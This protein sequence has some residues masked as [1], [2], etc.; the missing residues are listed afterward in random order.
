[1]NNN[2]R[3]AGGGKG[4]PPELKNR[5][6]LPLEGQKFGNK[7]EEFIAYPSKFLTPVCR[8]FIF[9]EKFF[10]PKTEKKLRI[11][12]EKTEKTEK[13]EIYPDFTGFPFENLEIIAKNVKLARFL[14]ISCNVDY[15]KSNF[16]IISTVVILI[17]NHMSL[18]A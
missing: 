5:T 14:S 15:Q 13:V 18:E 2:H 1:M 17:N 6:P 7:N 10:S 9:S 8:A 12:A 3:S 4:D 16:R 11:F